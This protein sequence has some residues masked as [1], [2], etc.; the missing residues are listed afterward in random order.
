MK[1]AIL[2]VAMLMLAVFLIGCGKEDV[3]VRTVESEP[4][5]P[6][7]Q[8]P[9]TAP[10]TAVPAPEPAAPAMDE[11]LTG[12]LEKNSKVKSMY[13]KYS[14]PDIFPVE[15]LYWV[16]DTKI[17]IK[18][19]EVDQDNPVGKI[20]TIYLDT[21]GKKATAY[22]EK[23]I[24]S[25]EDRNKAYPIIYVDYITK[26]PLDWSSKITNGEVLGQE[27]IDNRNA[28]RISTRIDG[29]DT[30]IWLDNFYGLPLKVQQGDDVYTFED[31]SVNSVDDA[32][33]EHQQIA[34]HG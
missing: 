11:E 4:A 32:D 28:V 5:A 6:S 10:T 15:H 3:E 2:V 30:M 24:R 19:T 18:Y 17:T 13:Y 27:Q 21:L 8:A 7:E 16:K 20:D 1:K 26:T 14:D 9:A 29:R 33:L 23:A 34:V 31:M 25:C 12:L 22:C